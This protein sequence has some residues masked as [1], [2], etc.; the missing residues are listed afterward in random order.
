MSLNA[1]IG[2]GDVDDSFGNT[3][4]CVCV[5][6]VVTALD[7]EL[8]ACDHDVRVAVQ[9]V[10]CRIQGKNTALNGDPSL[11]FE[12]L[13]GIAAG[14]ILL[15]VLPGVFIGKTAEVGHTPEIHVFRAVDRTA[16]CCDSEISIHND[17]VIGGLQCVVFAGNI[18][19]PV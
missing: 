9:A 19:Y 5:N 2:L 7:G 17:D 13:V 11:R 14:G 15:G 4:T 10:V 3:D 12:A 6:A 18:K 16:A 8:A 1:F